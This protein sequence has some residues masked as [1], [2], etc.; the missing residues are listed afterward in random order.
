MSEMKTA[1]ETLTNESTRGNE[2]TRKKER[3]PCKFVF[4]KSPHFVSTNNK[5]NPITEGSP[6]QALGG[7]CNRL[8]QL[9]L[10]HDNVRSLLGLYLRF[11]E[12][13]QSQL[14]RQSL[15]SHA[16]PIAHKVFVRLNELFEGSSCHVSG[17]KC[18]EIVRVFSKGS[19]KELINE[20]DISI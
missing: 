8:P 19:I 12:D 14:R 7:H 3:V 10:E 15:P 16:L 9:E 6:G 2:H 1:A 20:T 13:L 5:Q 18:P 17:L 4:Q 11:V